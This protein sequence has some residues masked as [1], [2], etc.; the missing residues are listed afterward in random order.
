MIDFRFLRNLSETA[1]MQAP[2]RPEPE[3]SERPRKQ[4]A[5]VATAR[6]AFK[7]LLGSDVFIPYA[8]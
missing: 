1:C 6:Q 8:V 7:I 4:P 3:K 5:H 2:V